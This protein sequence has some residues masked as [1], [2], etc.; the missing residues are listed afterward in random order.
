MLDMR[1]KSIIFF[2]SLLV[3]GSC[4][5]MQNIAINSIADVLS[6]PESSSAF[7]S[8][9]DPKLVGDSLPLILKL[10]EIVLERNPKNPELAAAAGRNFVIYSS[11]FVQMPADMLADVFWEEADAARR[12]AKKLYLRGK[13]YLMRALYLRHSEFENFLEEGRYDDAIALLDRNDA[14]IAY[15]AALAWFGMVSTDPLDI[16]L[17][18]TLDKVVLLLFRS[19]ELNDANFGI[20][21]AMIQVNL[22]LPASIIINLRNR[23]PHTA[24]YMDE[25]YSVA[26]IDE[27]PVNRAFFHYERAL[28][29]SEGLEPS[30]H[31][32]MATAFS[33]KEQDIEGFRKYLE[34]ALAID[35]DAKPESSLMIIIYQERA[36]WLLKNIEDFFI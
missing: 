15:W 12:R 19:M 26:G 11:A 22:T 20:H 25:Y 29:L 31:I 16:E 30:P 14:E 32:T 24:S 8:D 35:P 2:A 23:S 34:T 4:K 28:E 5:T 21:D 27:D 36:R 3:L 10:Y 13:D 33:I 17:I 7:T 9:N 6:S 18:S 1:K